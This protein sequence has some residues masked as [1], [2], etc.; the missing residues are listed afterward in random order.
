MKNTS[1]RADFEFSSISAIAD[2]ASWLIWQYDKCNCIKEIFV[3]NP[4]LKLITP[5]MYYKKSI[6]NL[7]EILQKR[8]FFKPSAPILIL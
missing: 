5:R 6:R 4:L 8:F 2:P 7:W 3:L 1:S